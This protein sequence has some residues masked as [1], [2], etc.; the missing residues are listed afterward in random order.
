MAKR[1]AEDPL[2]LPDSPSKRCCRSLC[3]VDM[4]LGSMAPSGGVSPPSLLAL[5]GS[6]SR[7]RPSYFEEPEGGD[8]E[9]ALLCRKATHCCDTRK[10]AASVLTVQ[11][12]GSFQDR[13][14]SSTITSSKKRHR[15]ECTALGTAIAQ[16][17][18]KADE[19]T[20]YEDCTYNSFQFWRVPL[21]EL[22]LSLLEDAGD[23]SQI[24]DKHEDENERLFSRQTCQK[25][26]K[27]LE[28]H[29]G[30]MHEPDVADCQGCPVRVNQSEVSEPPAAGRS[31]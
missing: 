25:H 12:S 10:H 28:M 31:Q 7:K 20:N 23:H 24:K 18:D 30:E 4:Q 14:S 15:D 6:R 3:S 8:E 13:R 2:L 19:D 27:V 29:P 17:N 1:R 26:M 5:L 22:D 9:A 21:P 16:V 11:A